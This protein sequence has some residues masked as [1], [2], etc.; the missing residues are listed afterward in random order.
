MAKV[1]ASLDAQRLCSAISGNTVM[2]MSKINELRKEFGWKCMVGF[3]KEEGEFDY[4]AELTKLRQQV[5]AVI[6]QLDND[7]DY[8]IER[9][10]SIKHN[11]EH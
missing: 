10:R 1:T 3:D 2:A 4:D 5:Q 11:A 8:V 6:K 9:F 7:D